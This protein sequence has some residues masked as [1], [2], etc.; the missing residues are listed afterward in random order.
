[1]D[2]GGS[3]SS[4]RAW[5]KSNC[6]SGGVVVDDA[7]INIGLIIIQLHIDIPLSIVRPLCKHQCT[8]LMF[9]AK[10]KEVKEVVF[11]D[12]A[13]RWVSIPSASFFFCC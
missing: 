3:R 8:W 10:R 6:L 9:T 2:G 12:H 13:R 5:G 11:D 7:V 4:A 1:M